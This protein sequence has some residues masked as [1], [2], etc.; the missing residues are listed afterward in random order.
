MPTTD[1]LGKLGIYVDTDF[2]SPTECSVLCQE[3]LDSRKT[4]AGTYDE[5]NEIERIAHTIRKTQ[6]C[7]LSDELHGVVTNKIKQLKPKLEHFFQSRYSDLFEGPKYLIYRQG[8]FFSPHIDSQLNR[9]INVTVFLNKQTTETVELSYQGGSLILYGLM[10]DRAFKNRG[11]VAP[12][13][14]G[15]LIAYPVDVVHEITPV[16]SGARFAIVSRFLS[17]SGLIS[18]NQDFH[19]HSI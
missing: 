1:L 5:K 4:E 3:M 16:L 10:K 2:M 13:K 14:A 7:H 19:V 11:I 9:K 15:C 17:D 8:D 6:Y 18:E 12:T